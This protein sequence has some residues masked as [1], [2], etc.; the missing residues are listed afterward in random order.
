MGGRQGNLCARLQHWCVVQGQERQAMVYTIHN[1][2][3]QKLAPLAGE[4]ASSHGRNTNEWREHDDQTGAKHRHKLS[5]SLLVATG[6]ASSDPQRG[7][8]M[9]RLVGAHVQYELASRLRPKL[10]GLTLL[11]SSF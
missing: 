6:F 11:R 4:G 10:V 3:P 5:R 2:S 1:A 7:P 9:H 8:G